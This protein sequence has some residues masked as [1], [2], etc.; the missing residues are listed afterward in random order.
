MVAELGEIAGTEVGQFVM[1]PVAPD[2]LDRIEFWC[3]GRQL[4]D[5]E[6]AMVRGDELLDRPPAMRRQSVP[7][8]QELARQ[9]A[10]QM[11]EE[12]GDFGG[13][14]GAAIEPEV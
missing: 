12:V 9:V 4:L 7:H 1:F 13:A 2:V 5:R 6:S 3:I 11:A 14:D 8:H 10:Q